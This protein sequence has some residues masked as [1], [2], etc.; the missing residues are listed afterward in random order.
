LK[1]K[2]NL[3]D[4]GFPE[5]L[6]DPNSQIRKQMSAHS[7]PKKKGMSKAQ[8]K[9][10]KYRSYKKKRVKSIQPPVQMI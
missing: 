3:D 9:A 6:L 1:K 2:N 10:N 8:M 5:D 7:N 4:D